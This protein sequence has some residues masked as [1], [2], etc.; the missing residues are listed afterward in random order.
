[1][2]RRIPSISLASPVKSVL[3]ILSGCN[4]NCRGCITIARKPLGR[5]LSVEETVELVLKASEYVWNSLPEK[6][7][8]GGGEPTLSPSYLIKLIRLLK[9]A[10]INNIQIKT[11]G[12]LLNNCMIK[13][14]KQSGLSSLV[15]DIKAFTDEIHKWYTGKSNKRILKAIKL[16]NNHNLNFSVRMILIPG[17][18]DIDEIRRM[19]IFL[20]HIDRSIP[21]KIY[22]FS[23]EHARE[24]I[25]HRP[26][27]IEL[28][29]AYRETKLHLDN[30]R[31]GS[32]P[33]T[34]TFE[35]I[36]FRDDSL[37]ERYAKI[38]EISRLLNRNWNIRGVPMSHILPLK[39]EDREDDILSPAYIKRRGFERV[40]K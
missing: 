19:C 23:P 14:L 38:D 13:E 17:I 2:R 6:V 25:S 1:M 31:V 3:L 5:E 37:L 35:Y 10:S 24:K 9:R 15:V 29:R 30:V 12:Y 32:D 40:K 18:V 21:F 34:L 28:L 11:N 20:S 27:R 36:E 4:F 33:E 8:I 22:G 39:G 26:S 16:L 7:M